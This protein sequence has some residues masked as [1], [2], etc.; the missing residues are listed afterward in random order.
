MVLINAIL[1]AHSKIE[2][3]VYNTPLEKSLALSKIF[4]SNV[5]LKC[6]HI[7]HTGSFKFR[8]ALNK[9]LSLVEQQKATSV[10]TASTGNHGQ[11]VAL[12]AKISNIEA[13]VFVPESASRIKIDNIINMGA[14]VEKVAGDTLIAE[15]KAREV[16]KQDNIPFISP[17]NDIEV[18]AGQ[19][20]IGLEL[21]NSKPDLDAIFISVGGGGLISG[22]SEYI[23]HKSPNTKI[24]GCWAL[25]A[26]AMYQCIQ[27]G[28]IIKV[29]AKPTISDGT[30]GDVEPEAITFDYCQRNIDDH[31]LVTEQEIFQ[32][33]RL[34][35]EHERWIIEGAS[36]VAV[37][38]FCKEAKKYQG[39]NIAIIL[40]GRNI[41]FERFLKA[42]SNNADSNA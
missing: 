35:G 34:I 26:P 5:Y 15:L 12:A 21:F 17:Y 1:Q 22:I 30:A 25:H 8:G 29:E 6:E 13:T 24:V 18:M 14:K 4:H 11:G 32:A 7:Q 23:K 38:A 33:M 19:G 3:H 10:I 40:C 2:K 16:S 20:T 39:K 42:T 31:I 36:G 9:V 28:K 27:Q 41:T 37:A